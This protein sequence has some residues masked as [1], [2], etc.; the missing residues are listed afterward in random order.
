MDSL[1]QI[2]LGAAVGEVLGGKK[3]GNKAMFWGA[4]AGTIP[5][6]DVFAKYFLEPIDALAAHR[7]FSH[8]FTFSI[9]GAFFFAYIV[10]YIYHHSK[11]KYIAGGSYAIL[12]TLILIA[13]NIS[14]YRANNWTI[15]YIPIT[16]LIL[17][18]VC[19]LIFRKYK[20]KPLNIPDF[21]IVEWRWLFFWCLITHPMLDC[22]TTYGTQFLLP[23][24]DY[25]IA[26]NSISVV[27]PV[28]TIFLI[29]GTMIAARLT[30]TNTLRKKINLAGIIL[31]SAYML[32]TLNN[33]YKINN[34]FKDSLAKKEI[35]YNRYMSNP[36]LMNN[37]L[38]FGI[39]ESDSNYYYGYYSF[40]D[41]NPI[42][43]LKAIEKDKTFMDLHK[44]NHTVKTLDWF[45]N[46]YNITEKVNEDTTLFR[47][48]RFGPITLDNGE[49]MYPFAM[50]LIKQSDQTFKMIDSNPRDNE[51]LDIS[52]YFS[53]L[54]KR[55]GF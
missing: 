50:T 35:N 20:K 52:K 42:F 41:K 23:F 18:G 48:L 37:L 29:L 12:T 24:S 34:I 44:E 15:W 5:D 31:S 3:L 32:I 54:I 27:D 2:A 7:G 6:L 9:L 45:S 51:D 22:F 39:A 30:K 14:F 38:W 33:K 26:F 49:D 53:K 40:L 47:D 1:T 55:I 25:R 13:S 19:L 43:K 46:G 17:A 16:G 21:N 4:V 10:H 36:T 11:Y 8:S 28:Y